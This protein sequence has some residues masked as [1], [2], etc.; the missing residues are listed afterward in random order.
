MRNVRIYIV[1]LIV[2]H[3]NCCDFQFLFTAGK[4]VSGMGYS[5]FHFWVLSKICFNQSRNNF[6]AIQTQWY[7]SAR[8][9][10][11]TAE[12]QPFYIV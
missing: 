12:I 9:N 11:A 5:F 6:R 1:Y 10:A 3:S 4:I 8:M 2:I 7:S